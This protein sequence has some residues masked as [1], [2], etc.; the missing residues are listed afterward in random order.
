MT[1]T[2]P[3]T[4]TEQPKVPQRG[5]PPTVFPIPSAGPSLD[6]PP[7]TVLWDGCEKQAQRR[8]GRI[9]RK[10]KI[11]MAHSRIRTG[12]GPPG[13]NKQDQASKQ[14]LV[15]AKRAGPARRQGMARRQEWQWTR[16]KKTTKRPQKAVGRCYGQWIIVCTCLYWQ[17]LDERV[18]S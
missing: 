18:A 2:I 14:A 16:R 4:T 15:L 5:L 9:V 6:L 1:S 10:R 11:S 3:K 17:S 12:R 8:G 7:G 13:R